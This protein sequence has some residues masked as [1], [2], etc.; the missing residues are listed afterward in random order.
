MQSVTDRWFGAGHSTAPNSA[1]AGREAAESALGTRTPKAILIFASPAH[2]LVALLDAVREVVGGGVAVVGGSAMGEISSSG[3]ATTNSVTVAAL[4]GDGFDVA[5]RLAY[6]GGNGHREAG[7]AVAGAAAGLNRPHKALVLLCDGVSGDP[8]EI[9]RGA[10]SELGAAVPLVGGLFANE[11]DTGRTF[12]FFDGRVISGGV[13]GL[14][15]ASDA[16]LGL[17]IAHGYR[18]TEP[19]MVI[20]RSEQNT[21]LELDGE[22][23]LGKFLERY[24]LRE[25]G[26]LFAPNFKLRALGLSRRSGE[27]IRSIVG[28]D[29][30]AGALHGVAVM[31]QGAVCW[32]MNSDYDAVVAGASESCAGAVRALGGHPPIGALA[33]DCGGRRYT[34]GEAG[35]RQETDAM[36]TALGG[37]PFAGMYTFGEIARVRG[38]LGVHSLTLVTLAL[39]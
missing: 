3:G 16:P 38:S 32:P 33:F 12:Q 27:D 19:P 36:R 18:R 23:A 26:D 28:V 9:V 37:A 29:E 2:D 10:Y 6:V 8:H 7:A 39:A 31:P 13:I 11:I 4:G 5:T 15:I 24:D 30:R 22:P 35:V 1:A 20:T 25:A 34:L 17:G 14:A 21:I